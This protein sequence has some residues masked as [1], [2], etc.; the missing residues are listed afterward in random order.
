M[1]AERR[2][3][4]PRLWFGGPILARRAGEREALALAL[5]CALDMYTTLWWVITGHAAEANPLLAPTFQT[6]PLAFVLVKSLSCL[7]ALVLAPHLAG[8]HPR[9]TIWLLRVILAAYVVIY[10]AAVQ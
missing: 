4:Q 10:L 1:A 8:R 2:R 3:N 7:P 5:I 6:H 9:F